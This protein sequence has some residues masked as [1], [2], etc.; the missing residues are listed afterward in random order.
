MRGSSSSVVLEFP[1]CPPIARLRR[2]SPACPTPGS[3]AASA[4]ICSPSSPSPCEACSVGAIPSSRSNGSGMPNAPSWKRWCRCRMGFRRMTRSVASSPRSIPTPSSGRSW[5]GVRRWSQRRRAWSPLTARR[6]VAPTTAPRANDRCIW[7]APGPAQAR[8]GRHR[9][10]APRDHRHSRIA[11][12]VG[13]RGHRGHDRCNG[14]P[15]GDCPADCG[16]G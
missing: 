7:S 9:R 4:M 14:L 16:R 8:S 10:Q 2:T 3:T 12:N 5:G 6:S 15:A 1:P 11:P 13:S